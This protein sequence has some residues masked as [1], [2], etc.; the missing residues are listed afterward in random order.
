MDNHFNPAVTVQCVARAHR[1]GQVMPVHCYRLA[2][3]GTLE[4]K[5][6]ARSENKSS[7]AS[8]VID[9]AYHTQKFTKA[10]LDDLCRLDCWAQCCKCGKVRLLPA[11]EYLWSPSKF[12]GCSHPDTPSFFLFLFTDQDPPDDEEWWY[13]KMNKDSAYNSCKV[14]EQLK[15]RAVKSD[16]TDDPILKHLLGVVNARTRKTPI[17]R[18]YASV[19][20][21]SGGGGDKRAGEFDVQDQSATKRVCL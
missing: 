15:P 7:V 6:Y 5:V 13:C 9:G 20:Q 4:T 8:G 10:E 12:C 18:D 14:P 19:Q 1:F 3:E 17:V 21:S 2:I 16:T 11:G